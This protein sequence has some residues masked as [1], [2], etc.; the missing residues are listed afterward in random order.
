MAEQTGELANFTD[1]FMS[2]FLDQIIAKTFYKR[3]EYDKEGKS[4]LQHDP[5][6]HSSAYRGWIILLRLLLTVRYM[7]QKS[8][9]LA[10]YRA[11]KKLPVKDEE[12]RQ[13]LLTFISSQD[14]PVTQIRLPFWTKIL[15]SIVFYPLLLILFAVCILQFQ[16]YK[17]KKELERALSNGLI[18]Y[19]DLIHIK[20]EKQVLLKFLKPD[21]PEKEAD[22][23]TDQTGKLHQEIKDIRQRADTERLRIINALPQDE[24]LRDIFKKAL[25]SITDSK[26]K[27]DD[28]VKYFGL[29]NK[30]L[31]ACKLGNCKTLI[32][33]L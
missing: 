27:T 14:T 29:L 12:F 4:L 8:R 2:R 9:L 28:I 5:L 30:E 20:T 22:T 18:R 33:R 17:E 11:E 7:N 1:G 32:Y 24:K 21:S 10:H 19:S 3:I 31:E 16:V 6:E 23:I 26:I 13:R 25:D 15:R